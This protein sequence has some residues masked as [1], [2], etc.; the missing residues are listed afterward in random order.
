M[1]RLAVTIII[2][3]LNC[4]E[5]LIN[6]INK[7]QEWLPYVT[8]II[9]IDSSSTDGT[10]EALHERLTPLGA[11]IISTGPGLYQAWNHGVDLATQ[12]ILYF[13]TIG[14]IISK[15]ELFRLYDI[16]STKSLDLLIAPP[17]MIDE[18]GM[19][20]KSTKW[21]IHYITNRLPDDKIL[22]LDP[23]EKLLLASAF[24][25]E[26][27]I[28]S[29]ASNM[30]RSDILKQNPFPV[31]FGHQG[32]VAWAIRNI[33]NIKTGILT[34][35]IG[36]FCHDDNR[37]NSY[38]KIFGI[39]KKLTLAY[40]DDSAIHHNGDPITLGFLDHYHVLNTK[41][42]RIIN[43]LNVHFEQLSAFSKKS[44][45]FYLYIKNIL[46]TPYKLLKLLA[47]IG[48]SLFC[49]RKVSM[50]NLVYG[51]CNRHCDESPTISL[52][53][54]SLNQAVFAP[55]VLASLDVQQYPDLEHIVYDAGSTDGVVDI[56]KK[57]ESE[58]KLKLFVEPDRGQSDAINKGMRVATGEIVGWL[59]SDDVLL[60]GALHTVAEAFRLNPQAVVICGSGGRVSRDG[61]LMK[62]VEPKCA[63]PGRI[64]KAFEGVQPAIFFKRNAYW[65]V[66]GLDESLHYAMD[67]DLLLKLSKIGKVITIP[68]H[69]A[70]IRY[71]EETKTNTG[72]WKRMREI[73]RIGRC[74]NGPLDRNNLSFQIRDLLSKQPFRL[75]RSLFDHL[76]WNLFKDPTL[77]VQ[78]WPGGSQRKN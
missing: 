44:L 68:Q 35:T 78:G 11:K 22:E 26:S 19:E 75:P 23:K 47:K 74:H 61:N 9:A 2:P 14:D 46:I 18:S 25:P 50:R 27:I 40:S 57:A 20:I 28:G 41:K 72:G 49:H 33:P 3:T 67:W 73:A 51:L 21:P 34:S 60:P 56:W 69:L 76:C 5:K 70:N 13:S 42:Y 77:M 65:K 12:P 48:T 8:E 66:G 36:N 30:Y 58:G 39:V 29:S 10:W 62:I 45:F 53:T 52:I 4:R 59:N 54:P 31:E 16:I 37:F 17:R 24:L 6:H 63:I 71:Y 15:E 7:S 32:D 43:S 1:T 38:R 64:N 55:E